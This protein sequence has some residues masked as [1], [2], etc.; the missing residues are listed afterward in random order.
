MAIK[1][2]SIM[3]GLSGGGVSHY[4]GSLNKLNENKS[5]ELTHTVIRVPKWR[6]HQGLWEKLNPCEILIKSRLDISWLPKLLNEIKKQNPDIILVHGFNGFIVAGICCL[7]KV[8]I[9]IVATYHGTYHPTTFF[10]LLMSVFIDKY[11]KYF[12]KYIAKHIIT[13]SNKERSNLIN[14][15]I[16]KSK[17][18]TIHN[19]ISE[20]FSSDITLKQV[21]QVFK[22]IGLSDNSIIIGTTSN[23]TRE[24]GLNYLIEALSMV[25]K[26]NVKVN[27]L[28]FGTGVL[29]AELK[30]Q[31]L[32]LEIS[33]NVHFMG[34]REDVKKYLTL[35]DIFVLPSLSEAHSISL[36]EAMQASCC[37][38][39]TDVGG[40]T[41][42]IRDGI[43]GIIVKSKDVYSLKK[44]IIDIINKPDKNK[45]LGD[46]AKMRFK[47]LFT[48]NRMLNETKNVLDDVHRKKTII[49]KLNNI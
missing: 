21:K 13:V 38:I 48:E 43:D 39:C 14:N 9:P 15:G 37:I 28:L 41:E 4:V 36:I 10:R 42:S 22:E 47:S 30:Q 31:C 18:V 20:T 45:L 49:N 7:S 25:I 1:V 33:N 34:F 19:G 27:L 3:W 29:E 8:N 26:D 17:I 40:N 11:S 46:S 5:L 35:L 23:F 2:L 6:K 12:L 44:A 24:K 32:S 16:D